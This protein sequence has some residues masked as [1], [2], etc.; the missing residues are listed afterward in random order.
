LVSLVLGLLVGASANRSITFGLDIVG[1]FLL[2]A[3][4]FT[5]NRGPVRSQRDAVPLIGPRFVRWATRQEL[6]ETLTS[7]AL[8]VIL[9]IAL[10]V[11]GIAADN[12]YSLF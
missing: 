1:C 6:E 9:G 10:I 11:L 5:G 8:F 12:R 2:V 4:F 7:S 3:G